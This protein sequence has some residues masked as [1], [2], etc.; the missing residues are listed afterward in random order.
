MKAAI[1][2]FTVTAKKLVGTEGFQP[3]LIIGM[4]ETVDRKALRRSV[5]NFMDSI[6]ADNLYNSIPSVAD[7]KGWYVHARGDHRLCWEKRCPSLVSLIIL[8]GQFNENC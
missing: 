2:F 4:I 1:L 8:Y 7:K 5:M 6:K 3:Y